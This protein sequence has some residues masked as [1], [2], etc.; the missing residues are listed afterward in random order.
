VKYLI[1]PDEWHIVFPEDGICDSNKESFKFKAA[2]DV[3]SDKMITIIVK[4]ACGNTATIKQ[5]F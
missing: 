1:R 3:A 2:L 5:T 4:D